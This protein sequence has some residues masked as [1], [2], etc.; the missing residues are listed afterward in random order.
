M[1]I[2]LAVLL[3]LTAGT[4]RADDYKCKE[5]D[6]GT[7][8]TATFAATTSLH[9]LSV[10]ILGFTCKNVVFAPDVAK[11]ATKLT[12]IA[13]K[14]MTPKQALQLF[15]DAV[16][17][18][19]L[20]VQQKPDTIVIKLGPNMPK[21]CP[22][23]AVAPRQPKTYDVIPTTTPPTPEPTDAE[24]GKAIAAIKKI[25]STHY[26]VPQAT[27]DLVLANP[28][29]ATKGARVV[30]AMKN[31][32]PEGI[33][34]YAITPVSLWAKIGFANGDTVTAVNGMPLTDAEAGLDIYV[35]LREAKK[36]DINLV[37]AGKP[38]VLTILIK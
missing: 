30:P 2:A 26:E 25:D 4:A 27:V 3:C 8:I 21:N 10:W 11:H 24:M 38:V 6:P 32:K 17:A 23:L 34:M 20:V 14:A 16:E 36:L 13:P 28:M 5:A 35:K 15:V 22:D 1:R 33:K 31:G 18:T 9:D 7:K 19:G 12:V 37:R 29:A